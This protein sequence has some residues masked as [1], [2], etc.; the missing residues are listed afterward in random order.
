MTEKIKW[1]AVYTR[2]RWEKKVLNQLQRKGLETYCPLNR[3]RRR[4]SDRYKVVEEP[5]FKSYVFV[6]I[7]ESEQTR[8]RL[9]DGVV[10]FVYWLGRPAVVRDEE[11]EA[12]RRFMNEF[13]EVELRP[14]TLT[15]GARVRVRN[16]VMMDAEG[17]VIRVVNNRAVVH[18]ESLGYELV[19]Q[20]ERNNLELTAI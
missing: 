2:P 3:V 8:I 16:G 15:E 1:H 7:D 17:V 20:F 5:L 6:R 14:L 11:I 10:N 4:W 13:Q 19:A 12:I 9:T 18:L